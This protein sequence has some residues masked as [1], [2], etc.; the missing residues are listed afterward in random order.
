MFSKLKAETL[1]TFIWQLSASG[2]SGV[3]E[4]VADPLGEVSRTFQELGI[5][6]V[7]Q[8]AK[9]RQQVSAAVTYD[10]SI[11]A[12]R[13]RV[14]DSDDEFLL[15]PVTVRRNDR[16]AQSVDE[17]IGEQKL[18]YNDGPEN[19]EPEE[20]RPMENYA[21]SITWPDGF[22]RLAVEAH[23]GYTQQ[24]FDEVCIEVAD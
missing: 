2:D 5:C 9:I 16:S 3:P 15:H 6:V 18:Q 19:I 1:I 23:K 7:Q 8:C 12:I 24:Q 4:V 14:P 17:R 21:M 22:S 11:K 10:K 13:V 20:I